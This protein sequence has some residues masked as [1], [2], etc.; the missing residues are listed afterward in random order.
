MS[1]TKEDIRSWLL[2]AKANGATHVIVVCDSYDHIDYPVNVTATENVQDVYKQYNGQN[3][4]IV[5]EVYALH[6]DLESQMNKQRSFHFE[7]SPLA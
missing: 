4:Q 1:T 7:C 2:Q 5:M 3:M 6:L